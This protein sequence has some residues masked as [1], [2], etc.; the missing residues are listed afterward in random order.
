MDILNSNIVTYNEVVT[1]ES[2]MKRVEEIFNKP[3]EPTIHT[4]RVGPYIISGTDYAQV[5]KKFVEICKERSIN[6]EK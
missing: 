6:E 4:L 5:I 2:F 3:E 1:N